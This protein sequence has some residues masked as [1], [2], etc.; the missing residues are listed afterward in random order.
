MLDGKRIGALIL[1]AGEGR[2][3]GG[4]TPKQFL[5]LAGKKVYEHTVEA[6]ER[7]GFFDEIV[8]VCH[9]DWA[10]EV[11]RGG[12]N[13]VAGGQ[14]R[15]ESSE[16]GLKAFSQAPDVVVIHDGVRP[17]VSERILRENALGA[18]KWGAVDTCFPSADTLVYA[19]GGERI[20]KIPERAHFLRGQTPQSFQYDWI[21]RAHEEAKAKGLLATDDCRLVVELGLPVGVVRGEEFNL[22][23]TTE[24]DL[25]LAEQVFRLRK[26]EVTPSQPSSLQGKVYA[27]VG[28]TGGIGRAVCQELKKEGATAVVLS[29]SGEI[30]LNLQNP[31]SIQKA[32]VQLEKRHG[33]VDGLINC[34][35]KL[36]VKPL[37]K[38]SL[39]E[40]EE[41]LAVNLQGLILCC[42]CAKIKPGGHVVNLASSSFTRGRK[43]SG[44]Y[45]SAK[46]GV[47]NFTQAL[48]EE[49]P[50]LRVWAVVPQR[51][52]TAMRQIN[53][54][55]ENPDTL[56][57]PS[58]VAQKVIE[59]LKDEEQSGLIAEVRKT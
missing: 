12:L 1:M 7:A 18:M 22:K 19:P 35:G 47:V 23:I 2:R 30:P 52:R 33:A 59:L 17:F 24:L 13:V 45:S 27:V 11:K 51:T 50:E 15:Q 58:A 8:L 6:F 42:Q 40:I 10:P 43:E 21:V 36:I 5:M 16:A 34:A 56:L 26:E 32:F 31:E 48:T 29:R 57:E 20:E 37:E 38:M 9:A 55:N 44:V 49:R 39:A 53:F 4:D 3:M 54:P 28:G 14:T 41:V 46:A 25:F